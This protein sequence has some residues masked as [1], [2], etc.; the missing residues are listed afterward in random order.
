MLYLGYF[1]IFHVV[2]WVGGRVAG[3]AEITTNSAQLGLGL[4]LSLAIKQ[5]KLMFITTFSV[6]NFLYFNLGFAY[7]DI[8][9]FVIA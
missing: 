4:G 5:K 2:G 1:R 6:T 8:L 7:I 9:L 3:K